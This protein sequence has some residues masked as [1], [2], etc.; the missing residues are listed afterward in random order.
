MEWGRTIRTSEAI[1]LLASADQLKRQKF[2]YICMYLF[3]CLDKQTLLS[4]PPFHAKPE[5]NLFDHLQPPIFCQARLL[6]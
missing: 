3:N 1:D 5:K 6:L 2:I 4:Y